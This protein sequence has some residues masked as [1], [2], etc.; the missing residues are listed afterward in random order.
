MKLDKKL[1]LVF[2][3][4]VLVIFVVFKIFYHAT[5]ADFQILHFDT[6]AALDGTPLS[7]AIADTPHAEETG[8]SNQLSL[9]PNQ[10]L[11]F[12]FDHPN[13]YGF[14]MKEMKFPI[15]VMWFDDSYKVVTIQKDFLPSSYP[16]I[17]YPTASSTYVLEV[18]A[19]FA[20]VHDIHIGSEL[21]FTKIT[22]L[23]SL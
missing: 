20:D 5:P 13:M 16:T 7:L 9:Q 21:G 8:L 14:W 19:G 6:L 18:P 23:K 12:V 11:L 10:G 4:L 2:F 22:P 15:D 3:A 1:Y 17:S